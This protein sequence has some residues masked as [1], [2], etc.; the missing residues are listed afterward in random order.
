VRSG[1]STSPRLSSGAGDP[2]SLC[3]WWTPTNS[4]PL[5]LL[6][7]LVSLAPGCT[8]ERRPDS[9]TTARAEGGTAADSIRAVVTALETARARGD[10]AAALALFDSGAVVAG[11]Q[12]GTLDGRGWVTAEAMLSG[13][14]PDPVRTRELEESSIS[15]LPGS[16][17]ALN[18]YRD[19]EGG[20][21]SVETVVLVRTPAG[22]RIRHI[23]HSPT[24]AGGG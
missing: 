5:L 19:P 10:L 8:F 7:L 3:F 11:G 22:W 15:L 9:T 24:P 16:A 2:R 1:L 23:H 14:A 21:P 12:V 18:R 17:L 6:L 13:A 20:L 4:P